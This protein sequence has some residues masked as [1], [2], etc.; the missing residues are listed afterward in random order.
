MLDLPEEVQGVPLTQIKDE[1][2]VAGYPNLRQ[3]QKGFF[4][5]LGYK[6]TAHD[7][8][9]EKQ[10]YWFRLLYAVGLGLVPPELDKVAVD[11]GSM[12]GLYALFK[13]AKQHLKYP[14][15][16]LSLA[17]ETPVVLSLAGPSA[18]HPNAI[19]VTDG[20]PYGENIWYGR[21]NQEGKWSQN[22]KLPEESLAKVGR[23][24]KHL[25]ESPVATAKK[26]ATLTGRCCFC[27]KELTEKHST[28]AGFGETCAKH[29]GLHKE[30]KA[31]V[32]VID[33]A[34]QE[35]QLEEDAQ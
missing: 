3:S 14:R 22:T 18:A 26:Y 31:A 1:M 33:Q 11:V 29:F 4:C 7:G 15:I 34:A 6:L 16:C 2:K 19:N 5:D 28:A 30:W 9:S 35:A 13:K 23:L 8:L 24:L 17:D 32:S 20:K 12:T 27:N 25:S 21:V 10:E